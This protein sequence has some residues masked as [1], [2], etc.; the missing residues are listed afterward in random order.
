MSTKERIKKYESEIITALAELVSY[1]SVNAAAEGDA[2][3][4][5]K[6]KE[7]LNAALALCQKYG[8]TPHNLDN[9]IGYGEI[10]TGTEVIGI[11]G[12]LDVV[13]AGEG[14]ESDP[15]TLTQKEDKLYG[16]GTSDDKGAV[17]A[18]L[19]ALKILQDENFK[20][21]KR[22]RLIMGCNEETG[23]RCL[24]HYV[25]KEGHFQYGFTPD[26][27]FPGVFGEKGSVGA[28]ISYS[29][30]IIDITGGV[31]PNVVCSRCVTKV[32]NDQFDVKAFEMSLI[33][34]NVEYLISEE[35][36]VLTLDVKGTAAH[37]STPDL[38]VNAISHTM[39]ALEKAG[40]Q[41]EFVTMYN[42]LIGLKTDGSLCG[43]GLQDEYG[44]LTLNI[45]MI[46]KDQDK[47]TVTVDI[48]VPLTID[49]QTVAVSMQKAFA[50]YPQALQI[51][52]AGA[53]LFYPVESPLV[54]SLLSAYRKVTNDHVSVPVSMGGG[55]YAKGVNNCIAFGCEFQGED[56]HIHD[57]NE[58]VKLEQLL[59]QVEIY[60]QAIKNLCQL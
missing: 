39:E 13:P 35:G 5:P 60:I 41:D 50:D 26:A 25:A 57:A 32:K 45:G 19:F 52:R 7:C 31:A 58:F 53:S 16:R 4:G 8:L 21:N 10:G 36:D 9:Y 55:T 37:A 27:V 40:F 46:K 51:R 59:L 24:E 29:S 20:F 3:F 22:V 44:A 23:S 54:N 38:G 28:T 56:N 15:F 18:S 1:N 12:H 47:V 11:L 48:R 6:N 33:E 2:P 14:W 30:K 43:I 49:S 42:A 34:K 17:I